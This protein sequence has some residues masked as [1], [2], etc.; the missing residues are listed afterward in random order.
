VSNSTF[1]RNWAYSNKGADGGGIATSGTVTV[2]NSTFAGNLADGGGGISNSGTL[3][4]SNCTFAG[5]RA[6]SEYSCGGGISNSGTV[7]VSNST[8]AGNS[9]TALG[10]GIKNWDG[11]VTLKNTIVANSPTGGNCSGVITDGGGNLRYPDTTCPGINGDPKLGPL[12]D[13]G[14]PTWTM[15]LGPGSAAIDAADDAICAATPVN[16]LDQ[17]GIVRPQGPHCDIGAFEATLPPRAYL[18]IIM[19]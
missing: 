12:Q 2:S 7:T 15:A 18:P 16:N 11:A 5:N 13:N 17:R 14:G 10:G 6:D 3:M 1:T 19:R 8:F 9:A 4:V